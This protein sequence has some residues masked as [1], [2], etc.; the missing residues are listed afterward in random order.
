MDE[1]WL[2]YNTKKQYNYLGNKY[3]CLLKSE[4]SNYNQKL[5]LDI[6]LF[7]FLNKQLYILSVIY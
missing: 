3:M 7:H 4:K 1:T 2:K 5:V 6:V